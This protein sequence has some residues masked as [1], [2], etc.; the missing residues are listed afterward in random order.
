VSQPY[1]RTAIVPAAGELD[2]EYGAYWIGNPWL[3]S[4]SERN[5]S[6]FERNRCY[7]NVNGSSFVDVSFVSGA[8]SDSDA[9][10]VAVGD[11]NNDGRPDLFVR[12]AGGGPVQLFENRIPGGHWLKV[13]LRGGRSNGLGVG[14]R[15]VAMLDDGTQL[16][17]EMFPADTF[18]SQSPHVLLFGLGKHDRAKR[19]TIRWPSGHVDS[20]SDVAADRHVRITE[21]TEA[22]LTVEGL[23]SN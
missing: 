12:N 11:Y 23:P 10:S 21:G 6:S 17:R 13:S 2:S 8:D 14:A 4:S 5:L 1:D 22:Y 20:L 9:R 19:L 7:L 3:I 15:V 18:K 16:T